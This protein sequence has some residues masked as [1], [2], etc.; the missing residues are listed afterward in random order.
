MGPAVAEET[1]T[2][3]LVVPLPR[4]LKFRTWIS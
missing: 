1:P 4:A 2:P 3:G